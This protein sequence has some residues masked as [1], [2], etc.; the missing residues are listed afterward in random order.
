MANRVLKIT[1]KKQVPLT[2]SIIGYFVSI[3]VFADSGFVILNPLNKALSKEAKISLAGSAQ[4][5]VL[6]LSVTHVLV[7]PTPGPIAAAGILKSKAHLPPPAS[8]QRKKLLAPPPPTKVKRN[9]SIYELH[10]LMG[11]LASQA[12]EV[13][14]VR[15]TAPQLESQL[16]NRVASA[17]V[18]FDP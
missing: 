8:T 13:S 7:P 14:V 12:R 3:P 10:V 11:Y 5:L 18:S 1:G 4:A 9:V 17:A 16:G 15:G 6:G 2:M